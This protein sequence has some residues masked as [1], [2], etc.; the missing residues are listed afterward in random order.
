MEQRLGE[1]DLEK[2]RLPTMVPW[3]SCATDSPTSVESVNIEFTRRCANGGSASAKAASRCSAWVFIV[4][5][6][7]STLSASVTVRPGP[8]QVE[9][10]DLELLEPQPALLDDVFAFVVVTAPASRAISISCTS[11]VP[12]PISRILLSR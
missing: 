8:V 6:V 7:N 12:S 9:R 10:A 11:V 1:G 3:V 2:P 5:V 4:S